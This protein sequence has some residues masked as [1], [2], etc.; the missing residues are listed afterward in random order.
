M[1]LG[2][3]LMTQQVNLKSCC[4]QLQMTVKTSI[5]IRNM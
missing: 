4:Q 3:C 2:I 1:L 5:K